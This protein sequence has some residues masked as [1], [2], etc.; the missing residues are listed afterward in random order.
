MA[1]RSACHAQEPG[2]LTI[3]DSGIG[4]APEDLPRIFE[5]GFTGYNGRSDKKSSGIGRF[6]ICA[7]ASPENLGC[8]ISASAVG[9]GTTVSL[10][11]GSEACKMQDTNKNISQKWRSISFC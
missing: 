11:F 9:I 10:R 6:I 5:K 8:E 2:V 7:D 1:V 3:A 4:I